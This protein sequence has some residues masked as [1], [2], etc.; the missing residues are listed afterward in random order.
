M[1]RK[2]T[3][4]N[5]KA[6][7]SVDLE[8]GDVTYLFGTNSLGKSSLLQFI[9][10]LKQTKDATDPSTVFDLGGQ[11]QLVNLG[12]FRDMV[13]SHQI[14][15][16]ISWDISWKTKDR[17]RIS[18][19]EGASSTILFEGD[20]LNLASCVSY[21]DPF[22]RAEY[23][24]YTFGGQE[25]SLRER[26]GSGR[27]FSLLPD[28]RTHSAFQFK[29]TLGR[30]WNVPGPVKT[31]LFP[32]QA[33][34]YYKNADFLSVF[35]TEYESLIDRVYYL[36]PLR[37]YPRREY[38][39]SGSSPEDVGRRGERTIDAILAARYRGERQN[40]VYKGLRK[41][42][43]ELIAY[44]LQELGLISSFRIEEIAPDSN[45]YKAVVRR[46]RAGPEALLTDVGF[47]VSQV[48]PA[49]VL[50][51]YVPE[52]SIVVMEQPEIH[53][54]PSVQSGLA[55][56]VLRV[57]KHRRLQIIV[58]SHSEHFLRR[59]QRRVAEDEKGTYGN[60]F[61]RAYFC[62]VGKSGSLLN[63]LNMNVFGEIENWPEGFFGDDFG[64][65]A[66]TKQ[67]SLKKRLAASG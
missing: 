18:D 27:G 6:W 44:W 53:L 41:P 22:M 26:A 65:I 39:W 67:A 37:D 13:Y 43:E 30:A 8:F 19:P 46:D 28:T 23:I 63:D 52:G 61:V 40:V 49:L 50:L 55:D 21:T 15:R 5:F 2:L 17:T 62:T 57:A 20:E 1:L 9:L 14:D 38:T 64:E 56:V 51:H 10:L 3:L 54:H 45:L 60:G 12:S 58:E 29:R 48:L 47:G 42:F 35:E 59:V 4:K 7:Q 66:R 16:K 33:Q 34:T 24:A 11:N 36:G 25:F 31:H 32:S